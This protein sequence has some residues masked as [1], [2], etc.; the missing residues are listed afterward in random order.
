MTH[1][2]ILYIKSAFSLEL[3]HTPLSQ[4]S[5]HTP[6]PH[7]IYHTHMH[8][9]YTAH[10]HT[11]THHT[12]HTR[13]H[14]HTPKYFV[15]PP[16]YPTYLYHVNS[17]QSTAQKWTKITILNASKSGQFLQNWFWSSFKIC[18]D[19]MPK[20]LFYIHLKTRKYKVKNICRGYFYDFPSFQCFKLTL[21]LES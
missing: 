16:S 11:H 13:T 18:W 17:V 7:T 21:I 3:T 4:L 9:P 12:L 15:L 5:K 1:E 2:G 10:T 14:T 19:K 6:T 20:K 8:T